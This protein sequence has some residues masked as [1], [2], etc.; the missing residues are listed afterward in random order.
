M[1]TLTPISCSF[2]PA[3]VTFR[4][5]GNTFV[6]NM[7]LRSTCYCPCSLR[8]PSS[9]TPAVIL[10]QSPRG[11]LEYPCV[12]NKQTFPFPQFR[13][14]W[15]CPIWVA[16]PVLPCCSLIC[17]PHAHHFGP[18]LTCVP[19]FSTRPPSLVDRIFIPKRGPLPPSAI[20]RALAFWGHHC[21]MLVAYLFLSVTSP[22]P[23]RPC[24]DTV[25]PG[26]FHSQLVHTSSS[27]DLIPPACITLL[28]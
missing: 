26:L 3:F 7:F 12:S 8:Y 4:P 21:E 6:H 10:P 13:S 16:P 20:L 27:S 24:T 2:P 14:C 11:P 5:C 18:S 23:S 22:H 25:I 1:P 15:Q 28:P 19:L 17:P 9:H